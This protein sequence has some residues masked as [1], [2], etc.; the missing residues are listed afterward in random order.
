[1][2][3]F[4]SKFSPRGILI[5]D[6]KHFFF[7]TLISKA[8][9]KGDNLKKRMPDVAA[10]FLFGE[11]KFQQLNLL[12]GK[13]GNT[14]QGVHARSAWTRHIFIISLGSPPIFSILL[15]S[16]GKAGYPS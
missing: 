3:F 6:I 11:K 9:E 1:V 4:F 2:S 12:L 15:V 8:G 5:Q 16:L 7:K 13:N 10:V 14:S